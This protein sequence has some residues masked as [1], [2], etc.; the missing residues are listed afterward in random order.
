MARPCVFV[1]SVDHMGSN[2]IQ[3]DVPHQFKEIAVAINQNCL[4]AALEKMAGAA[5]LPVDPASI[6]EGEVLQT[7]RQ[8]NFAGLQGKMNVVGHEA[9]GV[10]SIAEAASP[11]LQQEVEAAAVL[12]GKKDRLASVTAENDVVESTGEMNARFTY[13]VDNR[14]EWVNLPT[15]TPDPKTHQN[16][17]KLIGIISQTVYACK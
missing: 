4:E 8:R 9:E 17:L 10:H 6:A 12:V 11:F 5:F 15:S 3:V 7:A 1:G 2:R 14:V 13:H 16:A